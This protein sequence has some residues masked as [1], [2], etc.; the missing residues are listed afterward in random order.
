TARD[1]LL[2][3]QNTSG[4]WCF[5][6]E[7]DCTVPAEYI[8]MMHFTDEIDAALERKLCTYLRECQADN[9]GWCLY[10]GGELDVSCSVKA[11]FALKLGGDDPDA[12]H[13]HRAREAILAR[14]GAVNA[15]VFTHIALAL[16]GQ[17]PWRGVPFI[18]IEVMLL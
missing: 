16:Y 12:P 1:A 2:A 3:R 10:P 9:G 17:I 13:M 4:Y 14:G 11:Y 8:L 6:F 7:A 5:P 15:N 18:P